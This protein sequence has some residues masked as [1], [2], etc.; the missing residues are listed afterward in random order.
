MPNAITQCR[1]CGN[2]H[3]ELVLDLGVQHMTG[4]FP[5]QPTAAINSGP[6]RLVKCLGEGNCGLLQL[7]HSY[8]AN[9][10][11][12]ENYGYRSALNT[13]MVRHLTTK[14]SRHL[15]QYP[16]QP[17]A[18]VVDIG[19]NDSTT[20]Q[21]FPDKNLRLVG[22][23]PTGAK[24]KQYYP[25]HIELIA[26][27]F[28]AKILKERIADAKA[29]L[30]T[31]FAM[32]YDLEDPLSFMKD[33][34][35]ILEDDGLWLFE[36]SYLPSMLRMTSYDTVC[37]EHIEYYAMKQ[38]VWMADRAG[39]SLINAELNDINGGS[40]YV[41]AKKT[42]KIEH[43]A[44]IKEMLQR[45]ERA[46]LD[47]IAPYRAFAERVKASRIELLSFLQEAHRLGKK[48][49]ALGASTKGNVIL[50]YCGLN[51]SLVSEVGEVNEEK[52]GAYTPGSRLPIVDESETLARDFDYHLVLPWHFSKF[53]EQAPHLNGK[54]LVF[55]LPTLRVHH[56][57]V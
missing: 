3:L 17:G 26:D 42:K 27:F 20:L 8:D 28:S 36:Q 12:G 9:E 37:H 25:Q 41:I 46:E 7:Q 32:F 5:R 38:I 33:V 57:G 4:E 21:A 39:F 24:F 44:R 55:P 11:Y 16:L 52:F 1:I 50:Q 29:S 43:G 45:E 18:L 54:T 19:S 22:V 30:V 10:M 15:E 56:C 23:D 53:F 14:I 34:H 40:F 6:L 49:C 51:E 2:Q 47:T 31:S 35:E 48:T 13:S